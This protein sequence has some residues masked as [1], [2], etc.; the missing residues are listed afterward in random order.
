[1]RFA[2]QREEMRKNFLI[3]VCERATTIY[4]TE[5]KPNVCGLVLAGQA[6]FKDELEKSP[7]LDHRLRAIVKLTVTVAYGEY[8]GL[9][10]AIRLS[11]EIL[12][13]LRL[14]AE[15]KLLNAFMTMLHKGRDDLVAYGVKSTVEALEEGAVDK[16]LVYENLDTVRYQLKDINTG[17]EK[18]VFIPPT[19][20]PSLSDLD[21]VE[22]QPLIEWL[23][24]NASE[25][26][27]KLEFVTDKSQEGAMLKL[28]FDGIGAM[29]RYSRVQEQDYTE[30]DM[31]HLPEMG[32]D[33][34]GY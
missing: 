34:E 31:K 18:T 11:S 25:F 33:L 16:L 13:N 7:H 24:D 26:G 9:D 28:G 4:L 27:S 14:T 5:D 15:I 12:G 19:S 22:V 1:M 23:A 8:H 32:I 3:Q 29:L 10:E 21:I 20:Q 2:R 6:Q 17:K 30:N